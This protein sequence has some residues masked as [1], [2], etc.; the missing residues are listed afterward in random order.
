MEQ[1]ADLKPTPSDPPAA[2]PAPTR[3]AP[4]R[5][6]DLPATKLTAFEAL[7]AAWKTLLEHP[8]A[9]AS[10]VL[11]LM[12]AGAF[13]PFMGLVYRLESALDVVKELGS[14]DVDV[15]GRIAAPTKARAA[16]RRGFWR[17]FGSVARTDLTVLAVVLVTALFAFIP[18]A[19]LAAVCIA[20]AKSLLAVSWDLAMVA[21]VPIPLAS[22]VVAGRLSVMLYLD[23]R[24]LARLPEAAI[25][26]TVHARLLGLS[27]AALRR[28]GALV[29][30]LV[31]TSTGIGVALELLGALFYF[32]AAKYL[33]SNPVFLAAALGLPVTLGYLTFTLLLT[34]RLADALAQTVDTA[35]VALTTLDSASLA[36]RFEAWLG[37]MW[38]ALTSEL[39]G[40]YL[41]FGAAAAAFL[42]LASAFVRGL[43]SVGYT[44]VAVLVVLVAATVIGARRSGSAS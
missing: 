34:F 11:A 33:V 10:A 22:A 2:P 7:S 13:L 20:L 40:R 39:Q 29:W 21:Y 35:T 14:G 5:A 6:D 3:Y 32:L 41:A 30:G 44:H 4:P 28:N 18:V 15:V 36:G 17:L 27:R 38:A 25:N 26:S 16:Y 37:R 12:V 43:D 23:V 9:A 42:V 19:L 31:A 8:V 1:P 24:L